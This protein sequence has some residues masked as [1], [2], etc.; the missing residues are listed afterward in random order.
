MNPIKKL[1]LL[2]PL[3]LAFLLLLSNLLSAKLFQ[4]S[5][6]H[7][8]FW[9]VFLLFSFGSGW[10]MNSGYKWENGIKAISVVTFA[11]IIVSLLLVTLMRSSFDLNSSIID[12]FVHYSLRVFSIGSFS[13]FGFS[14]AEIIKLKRTTSKNSDIEDPDISPK[15][16]ESDL[17]IKEAKLKAEKIIFEA[18]K[19][20]QS[21]NERKTQVE[22]QLRELIQ[23]EREVIRNYEKED[24]TSND[25]N[26]E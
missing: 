10:I 7:F 14:I 3:F 23:T 9:V 22:I 5:N 11:S 26:V 15:S 13:I 19:E 24:S 2:F 4:S 16:N 25:K 1:Y 18:E 21:I 17:V 12:N 8:T 20:A 6:H